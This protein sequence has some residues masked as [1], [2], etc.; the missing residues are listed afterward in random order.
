[1]HV[2]FS[3]MVFKIT[4]VVPLFC[5]FLVMIVQYSFALPLLAGWLVARWFLG[6]KLLGGKTPW[7]R[8]DR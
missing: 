7:W 6:G 8:D 3:S 4:Q 5:D 2:F 1:M